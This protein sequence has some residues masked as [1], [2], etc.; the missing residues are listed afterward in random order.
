MGK[1]AMHRRWGTLP[2]PATDAQI[3]AAFHEGERDNQLAIPIDS[4]PHQDEERRAAWEA[5]WLEEEG[6]VFTVSERTRR[7]RQGA[8]LADVWP[9][10]LTS[11]TVARM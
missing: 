4:N 7:D 9:A 6:L 11:A 5:G 2:T 3:V 8:T 1:L 10:G